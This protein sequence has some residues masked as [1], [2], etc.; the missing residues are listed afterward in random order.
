VTTPPALAI[1]GARL[2]GVSGGERNVVV[3]EGRVA[4]VDAAD[5]LSEI[6]ETEIDARGLWLIPG[7]VD[8]HAHVT[9]DRFDAAD[10]SPRG[11]AAER[12]S[13]AQTLGAMLSAG[14]T[15]ARDAG[16][17]DS[18]TRRALTAGTPGPRLALSVDLLDRARVDAAGG[19]GPAVESVLAAGADW[20]KLVAT[21]GV[22]TPPGSQLVSHF[23]PAEFALATRLAA[24]AGARVMVHAWG[25]PA[26]TDALDAGVASIEHGIFLTPEQAALGTERGTVLVPTLTIYLLVQ[27]MIAAGRLP[28]SFGPRVAEAVRAHPAAV[29]TARDA[30]MPI[31]V[32]SD[33]ST[34]EQHG[35]NLREVAE[36]R[37]AGLDADEALTAAT[38]TGARLLAAP[39]RT[40]NGRD[41]LDLAGRL[42]PGARA[43]AVLLRS[44]PAVAE[45]FRDPDAV[46][47]V[48]Q[49]GRL[50]FRHP[51]SD[52]PSHLTA[53]ARPHDRSTP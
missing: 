9:W 25:G 11:S 2:P 18:E 26:I 47:A 13:T 51:G 44:D 30:G 10:R 22:A 41:P 42:V 36:L 28:A 53:L 23:S 17:A 16:G 3:H 46:V 6:A 29:R 37:R 21:G 39:S 8:A 48:V 5:A 15:S 19:M 1:R 50:V 24:E 34:P 33:Y 7:I 38:V 12:R 14:V 43:D 27:E 20:V 45:T 35:T 32:G 31:A 40:A 4:S 49:E 52:L